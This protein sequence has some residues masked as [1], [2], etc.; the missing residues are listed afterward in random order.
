MRKFSLAADKSLDRQSLFHL[1]VRSALAQAATGVASCNCTFASCCPSPPSEVCMGF[2]AVTSGVAPLALLLSPRPVGQ[3]RTHTVLARRRIVRRSESREPSD[4]LAL[5]H[6]RQVFCQ[7][8][9]SDTRWKACPPRVMTIP[10]QASRCKG[11]SSNR[12]ASILDGRSR[13]ISTNARNPRRSIH[14]GPVALRGQ[15]ALPAA[16]R[17]DRHGRGY[18]SLALLQH[19]TAGLG[20]Q[21]GESTLNGQWRKYLRRD[22]AGVRDGR[23]RG[24]TDSGGWGAPCYGRGARGNE[25]CG[26]AGNRSPQHPSSIQARAGKSAC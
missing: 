11:S 10:C 13:V 18:L 15:L 4:V 25:G 8:W 24:G 12:Q 9:A 26:A 6:G 22:G 14:A 19:T 21:D 17:R 5:W 1:P 20:R 7:T 2:A 16:R 23:K 3:L